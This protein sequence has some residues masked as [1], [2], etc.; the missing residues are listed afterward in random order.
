MNT[1]GSHPGAIRFRLSVM[2]IVIAILVVI[3]FRYTDSMQKELERQSI[4]QTKRIIDSSLAVV[5]ASYAVKGRLNDLNQV[6]GANPFIFL[7]QYSRADISMLPP[8]YRGEIARENL[9]G[10]KPGWYYARGSGNVIYIPR[11][12]LDTEW[13]SL[14]LIY[15]DNNQS[16][17]FEADQD[18]FKTLQ[19]V[20]KPRP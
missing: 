20:K 19:F 14:V 10:L 12:L 3:F 7:E 9:D 15:D 18:R 17:R 8:A 4:M 5:F 11:F 6:N 1:I 13:Y 16:G 2:V